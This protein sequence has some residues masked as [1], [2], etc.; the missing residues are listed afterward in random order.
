[1]KFHDTRTGF[2]KSEKADTIDLPLVDDFSDSY[3]EPNSNI[4][5]DKHVYINN[6]YPINQITAGVATFDA[7]D[8]RGAHYP[9]AGRNP[10]IADY[11][12]SRPVN[13]EYPASDNI[14][15][16]FFYQSKGLGEMPDATDS[17]CLEFLEPETQNWNRIWS[18]P[19]G[20]PMDQFKWIIIPV[21]DEKFL[22]KGFRFRFLNYASQPANNE[23]PDKFSNVD[24]W[25]IDYVVL[26]RNRTGIDSILRDVTFTK[27]IK[28][29]L[30]D[31]ESIPWTHLE[32]AYFT[33]RTASIQVEISNLDTAM[34]NV[35][36]ALEIRDMYSGFRYRPTPTAN[37]VSPGEIFRFDYE[38]DYP[39][40]FGTGDSAQFLI[41][42]IL[43]TDAFDYKPNDTLEYTQV[44][45]NFYA[46]DDG[47]AEAGYGLR[48]QGTQNAS[49]AVRFNSYIPDSLR[50]V[51]IYFNQVI[52]SINLNYYF[53]LEVWDD[54]NGK[55][56]DLI[57]SQLG[58]RPQYSQ[59]LNM[60]VRY[61]LDSIIEVSGS[62]YVGWTKTVDK[63]S[64]IGLDL[65][66]NNSSNNFY[67]SGGSWMQS[68]IPGSIMLRPVLSKKGLILENNSP[69]HQPVDFSIFPNP[70]SSH[71]RIKIP[72]MEES[73][74][75]LRMFDLSGRIVLEQDI[76]TNDQI[77]TGN[78][79]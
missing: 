53:F 7:Y 49:V 77:F 62:F 40:S 44:F 27:P 54:N 30:K 12:T 11:L 17:L 64:N 59:K 13:L 18:V 60:P 52:D 65:N 57:Y 4:W 39:F 76:L 5:S 16:S 36:K 63:L 66:R 22:R 70:V 29:M 67:T 21:K 69:L 78:L 34:R 15:L 20:M 61:A 35:T 31:Y 9:G 55:P 79:E 25:H 48:G 8:F 32:A 73:E 19:G 2:K 72:G 26:D 6:T 24:H 43:R 75:H 71:F 23:Y 42:T 28:S 47:S 1:M 58:E 38:Y 41:R 14:F 56:G 50:A 45:N 68:A 46:Y 51:D 10:Y 74:G 37:D 3:I 33:Q